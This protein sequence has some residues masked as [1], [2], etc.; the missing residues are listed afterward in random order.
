MRI[1]DKVRELG[2]E[3]QKDDR[4]IKYTECCKANEND[5]ELN[6]LIAK[7]QLT[8]LSYQHESAKETRDE[9]VL[10]RLDKEFSDI[11]SKIIVNSNMI[12]FEESKKAI[13]DM[14]TYIQNI[15]TLCVQGED[16]ATCE[17]KLIENG[18]GGNCSACSGCH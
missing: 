3:I 9:N 6:D 17:P 18:C 8:Q 13:D 10:N 2:A 11:Y 12:A 16:P 1:E 7:L 14:M 4:Y 15:L 5:N